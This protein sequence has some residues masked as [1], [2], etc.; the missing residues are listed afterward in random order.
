MLRFIVHRFFGF[1]SIMF[2]VSIVIFSITR[3]IPGDPA[4]VLLGPQATLADIEAMRERLG[5]NQPYLVQYA[6]FLTGLLHGDLGTSIYYHQS[7]MS[8]I[9]ERLPNTIILGTTALAIAITVAIPM[10]VLSATKQY[11]F[12][13]YGGMMVALIGVSM[14][15]FWL[16]LMLVLLFS[17]NLGWLP[18]TGMG[19]MKEGL[20]DFISHLILPSIA[21]S[22]IPMATLARITRS[23]TLEVIRSDYVR[24]ARAKGLS[25]T[26]VIWKHAFRNALIPLLTVLGLQISNMLS[27][28]VLTETI[29]SWPGMG[30]L[31]VDAIEKRDFVMVQGNVLFV[32]TIFVTVNLIIDILY[33]VAN[34]KIS[35]KSTGR[36]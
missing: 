34:P 27:G 36:E 31:I 4:A 6:S 5:L 14:P 22:T 33:A 16:G 12:W 28:A 30:R 25:E 23:S 24:T 1:I 8:L 9:L 15:V 3:M 2:I 17:V 7:V 13:D 35:V 19:S 20:W 11:S 26:V 32:V 29:F 21:L 10:G 18:A